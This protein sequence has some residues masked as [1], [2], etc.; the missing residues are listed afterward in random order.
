MAEIELIENGRSGLVEVVASIRQNKRSNLQFLHFT[1]VSTRKPEQELI[2]AFF[3]A[4]QTHSDNE[5]RIAKLQNKNCKS[6]SFAD[7]EFQSVAG[8]CWVIEAKSHNSSDRHNTVHKIFGELLKETGRINRVGCKYA[9]LLPEDGITFYSRAFQS[10][11]RGKFLEFGELIPVH[12]V[13][14][15]GS[16]GI[17]RLTWTDLYDAHQP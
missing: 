5:L 13:F 9:V 14:A 4:L 1:I 2:D 10:I 7:L 6:K 11:D 3:T 12:A 17:S 16:S 15:F 8:I